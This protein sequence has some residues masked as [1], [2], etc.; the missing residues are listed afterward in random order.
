MPELTRRRSTDAREACW[1]IYPA[2][3]K[4]GS[5]TAHRQEASIL[6]LGIGVALSRTVAL[7]TIA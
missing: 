7:L 6:E 1:Q 3:S 4:C 2:I 5:I